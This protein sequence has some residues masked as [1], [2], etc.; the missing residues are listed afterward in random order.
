[1]SFGLKINA[2]DKVTGRFK[3]RVNGALVEAVAKEK[4]TGI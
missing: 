1:M 4:E 2:K 3:S